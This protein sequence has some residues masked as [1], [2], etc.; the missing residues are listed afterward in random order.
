[1]AD[2]VIGSEMSVVTATRNAID[3]RKWLAS[4][5]MPH[6]YGDQPNAV[7]IANTNNVMVLSDARLAQLQALRQKMIAKEADPNS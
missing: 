7:A 6:Q 4:K 2:A 5:L 1:M 3:V